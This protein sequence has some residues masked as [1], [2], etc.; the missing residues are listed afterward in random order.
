MVITPCRV[1]LT[2]SAALVASALVGPVA[3]R[4]ADPTQPRIAVLYFDNNTGDEKLDVLQK[5]FAD[6]MV[7]DLSQAPNLT[8]VEREKLEAVLAEL[9]LQ[10][11][12]YF[13][14][15][16][17]V[18]IG[19][20]LGATHAVTGAF[21]AFDPQMRIDMRLIDLATGEV[22]VA[23]KVAGNKNDVFELEQ[24][25]VG[26]FLDALSRTARPGV[27]TQTRVKD[28][29]ALLEYARGLDLA[30]KGDYQG[31]AE[32]MKKVVSRSPLFAL[33]RVRRDD[34]LARLE[35]ARER[36]TSALDEGATALFRDAEAAL[37]KGGVAKAADVDASQHVIGWRVVAAGARLRLLR[38]ALAPAVE[39]KSRY[40]VVPPGGEKAV[41]T[42]LKGYVDAL[43]ALSADMHLHEQRFTSEH[44]YLRRDYRLPDAA[45]AKA[46]EVG[47]KVNP[48]RDSEA[49]DLDLLR[50]LALGRADGLT[51]EEDFI[52]APTPADLDKRYAA[53]AKELA[54]GLE[55]AARERAKSDAIATLDVERVLEV[56]TDAAVLHGDIEGAVVAW[57]SFLD[58]Y[59]TSSQFKRVDKRIQV[60]LGVA[61]DH[62]TS[63]I[64]RYYQGIATCDDDM[65]FRVGM[66]E[67]MDRRVRTMG[68]AGIPTTIDEVDKTCRGKLARPH[69]WSYLYMQGALAAGRLDD[70]K[71]FWVYVD[72]YLAENGS[73]SDLTGYLDNHVPQCK[74][75]QPGKT[76]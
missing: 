6:M 21:A 15:K 54:K 12:S 36:R 73:K 18:A 27:V 58:A 45:Q 47:F 17:A 71:T 49:A 68:L 25:L 34:F 30:D 26:R 13:D 29:D 76:P 3:A 44:G 55:A 69:F 33:A 66:D 11:K 70:C 64:A 62:V 7:T 19:N 1:A 65:D 74:A 28:V 8:V 57:Q 31:A 32:R 9:A 23:D 52:L 72:R 5:G 63:S 2:A 38:L 35:K 61:H 22:V 10:K 67:V 53:R 20:G 14:P 41:A 46:R 40:A 16:T 50:F 59:P 56:V 51:G 43:E 60:L 48:P 42:A 4:A 39:R 37:A 24:Q 75:S